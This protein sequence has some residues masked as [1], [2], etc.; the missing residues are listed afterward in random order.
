MTNE[1]Q[2]HCTLKECLINQS[3][4]EHEALFQSAVFWVFSFPGLHPG[5]L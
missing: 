1:G 2:N 4:R 5:L 3:G